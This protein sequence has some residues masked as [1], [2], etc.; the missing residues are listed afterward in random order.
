MIQKVSMNNISFYGKEENKKNNSNPVIKEGAS[1]ADSF[2]KHS[3]QSAPMLLAL[4]GLWSFVDYKSAKI[5]MKTSLANN[6]KSFFL[7]VMLV[8]SLLLSVIDNKNNNHKS[9]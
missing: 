7:P 1:Y 4:T 9:K 6:F 3:V 8:S 5:P 2:V